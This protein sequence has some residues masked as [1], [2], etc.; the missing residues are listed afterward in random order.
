[1]LVQSGENLV[2][3]AAEVMA[4]FVCGNE[5]I[6]K[7]FSLSLSKRSD[8]ESKKCRWTF[9]SKLLVRFVGPNVV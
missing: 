7:L 3:Q 9:F 1:M 6:K 2:L 5:S 4:R 8:D